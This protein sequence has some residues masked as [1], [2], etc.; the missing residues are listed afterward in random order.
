MMKVT[1]LQKL[2]F[3]LRMMESKRI[4]QTGILHAWEVCDMRT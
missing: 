2:N 1:K 4:G 3:I